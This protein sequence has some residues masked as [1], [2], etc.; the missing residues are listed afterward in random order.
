[1]FIRFS[2]LSITLLKRFNYILKRP[3]VE[4]DLSKQE[5]C[6]RLLFVDPSIGGITGTSLTR[7]LIRQF[8]DPVTEA[9]S[10]WKGIYDGTSNAPL[11]S[12]SCI[13]GHPRIER[14]DFVAFEKLLEDPTSLNLSKGLNAATALKEAVRKS[15]IDNVGQIQNAMFKEAIIAVRDE[16]QSVLA[17]LMSIKPMF[18]RFLSEFKAS[19][20]L[21]IPAQLVGIFQNRFAK[22]INGLIVDSERKT[23]EQTQEVMPTWDLKIWDC[24]SIQAYSLRER[25]WGGP[26]VGATIP[27]P[28]EYLNRHSAGGSQCSVL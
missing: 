11:M 27:N 8:P 7:F 5:V 21:G 25:S 22:R 26:V 4:L 17:F 18:P 19:T 12:F 16:N 20:F 6:W 14:L 28:F 13:V 10:F 1:M 24:S 9:L 15:L 2:S 23:L 3:L